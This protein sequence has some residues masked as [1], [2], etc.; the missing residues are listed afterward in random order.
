MN[1]LKIAIDMP[2]HYINYPEFEEKLDF[3]LSQRSNDS[4]VLHG[5]KTDPIFVNDYATDHNIVCQL[6]DDTQTMIETADG[7]IA[8]YYQCV[9]EP[10]SITIARAKNLTIK[11]VCIDKESTF[12][13]GLT[14]HRPTKLGGYDL[15]QHGY[16]GLQNHLET[17]IEM[18]LQNYEVVVGHSGLALGADTIW[19][20]AI[21]AMRNKYPGRVKFHA[22]IPMMSQASVWFK[23]ADID[24]WQE[25]VATADFKTVYGD[26]SEFPEDQHK[27]LSSKFLDDRNRGMLDHS[28]ELLAVWDGSKGGT[29]NAVAYAK[30]TNLKTIVIEPTR[31]F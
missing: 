29:G 21:L 25:Q 13:I 18:N 2:E 19:S 27:K 31:F 28:D 9:T 22:E 6:F 17:I 20:K 23:K 14:G 10:E 1:K 12:H 4:V 7:L 26:L 30:K 15:S 3:Y 8:F 16:Q 5:L 24:F 11:T